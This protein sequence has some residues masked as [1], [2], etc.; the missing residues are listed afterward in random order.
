VEAG[1]RVFG[2]LNGVRTILVVGAAVTALIAAA[3]GQWVVT[4]VLGVG[5]AA[6]GLLWGYLWRHRDQHQGAPLDE[7]DSVNLS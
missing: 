5:I 4:V 2:P 7:G 6:H 3:L 1:H